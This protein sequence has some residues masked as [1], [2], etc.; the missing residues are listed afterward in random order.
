MKLRFTLIELLVVIAIIAILAAMLLPALNQARAKAR[1]TNCIS[2]QKQC[3]ASGFYYADDYN[4]YFTGYT[5]SRYWG[6]M[7]L[8]WGYIGGIRFLGC[9]SMPHPVNAANMS[10]VND[11]AAAAQWSWGAGALIGTYGV[12]RPRQDMDWRNNVDGKRDLLG[13]IDGYVSPPETHAV[14]LARVKQPS[15]FELMLDTAISAG[16]QVGCPIASF[17]PHEF[18]DGANQAAPWFLHS[19]R[20]TAGYADGH[21]AAR[22]F[23]ELKESPLKFKA[24]LD[25]NLGHIQ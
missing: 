15:S 17:V 23:Q 25:A 20:T 13:E 4:G 24:G 18:Y 9:P 12:Y 2:N 21:V 16:T 10:K 22:T 11:S 5:R 7:L 8:D 14:V 1:Q 3:L 6:F 19:G